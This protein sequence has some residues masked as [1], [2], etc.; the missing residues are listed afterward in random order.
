[1]TTV[2]KIFDFLCQLAPLDTQMDFDNSGFLLG[3]RDARV[4]RALLTLDIT[5]EVIQEAI[6][7]E[8]QLVISHHPLIWG[9]L[10]SVT[11]N[12]AGAKVLR[13][14]ECGIAAVSMHTNLDIAQGGVNDVLMDVLG[15]KSDTPLDKYGCGRV[16]MLKTCMTMEAFLKLC[17]AWLNANGL[18]YYD[19]G[20]PVEKLAVMGGSG[21]DA[22]E[23]AYVK[24]C[25]TYLTADVK[26]H[27]FLLAK[28]LN[29]NLI[30]ADHFCTEYPVIPVLAAKLNEHFEDTEFIVS[31]QHRQ[32]VSFA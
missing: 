18:R 3:H 30:D 16:G 1:M 21:G 10:K 22:I 15:A 13:M 6:D 17:K 9:S 32:T 23:D 11:D 28:E 26:Y 19:A 5:D 25:D 2:E 31:A 4:S 14:A 7:T 27:Q 29:I 24:G 8:A 12:A 20:R